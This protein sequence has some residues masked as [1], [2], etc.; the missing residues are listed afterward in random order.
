MTSI[1]RKINLLSTFNAKSSHLFN[2]DSILSKPLFDEYRSTPMCMTGRIDRIYFDSM[3]NITDQVIK[4]ISNDEELKYSWSIQEA[5]IT[6]SA[7]LK[8]F[9]K[10]A[11]HEKQKEI[12]GNSH[13]TSFYKR[14]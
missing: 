7:L 10:I 4:C 6:Q 8:L 12:T 2:F 1:S 13:S 9:K 5:V 11:C 3:Y 14:N